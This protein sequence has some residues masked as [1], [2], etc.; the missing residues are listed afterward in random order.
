MA[1]VEVGRAGLL[2]SSCVSRDP[3]GIK[4]QNRTG[5]NISRKEVYEKVTG[6]PRGGEQLSLG[7][8]MPAETMVL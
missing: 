7:K 2:Y 8:E 1:Q 3:C 5:G 4:G 6:C